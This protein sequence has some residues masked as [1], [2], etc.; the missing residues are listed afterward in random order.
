M[1]NIRNV[2]GPLLPMD[3]DLLS[4]LNEPTKKSLTKCSP[5]CLPKDTVY[6]HDQF[7]DFQ[8]LVN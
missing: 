2:Q 5:V 8:L 3:Q 7:C 6:D 1:V 4:L